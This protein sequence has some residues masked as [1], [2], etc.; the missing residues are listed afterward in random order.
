M[1][2]TGTND[3]A[4][5]SAAVEVV[6]ANGESRFLLVCEHASHLMPDE[7]DHL[8]LPPA[9]WESHI[10]WDPGAM[11][12]ARRVSRMLDAPLVAPRTSRLIYDCNRPPESASAIPEVSESHAIPGN[13]GLSAA[14][15]Q[16]RVERFYLPFR[17]ALSD[18]IEEHM[19][20][21]TGPVIVTIH[22]FTPTFHGVRRDL[23]IGILHDADARLADVL[24][25]VVETDTGLT[26]RRNAPYAPK[27]GVTHTLREQ[28]L[29]RG[30]ANV[31]IEIRN[32]LIDDADRQRAM[33]ERLA[34][35]LGKA[36]ARLEDALN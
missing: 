9:L 17:N 22:S 16:A 35:C 30:L 5:Q 32:D 19:T 2:S 28:A 13:T 7:F 26:V 15:R 8:G 29:P 24:I 18:R 11:A 31:M 25:P 1:D 4:P 23:D 6:N 33:G 10:A 14:A 27:D 3:E 12:V 36:L 20:R 34:A 21:H